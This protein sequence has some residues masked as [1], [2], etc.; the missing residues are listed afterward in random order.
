M[1][2]S[3]KFKDILLRD[4]KMIADNGW[5]SNTIVVDATNHGDC[6]S[7][8]AALMKKDSNDIIGINYM[9]VGSGS[10]DIE[11]LKERITAIEPLVDIANKGQV[12]SPG[13]WLW[14]KEIKSSDIEYLEDQGGQEVTTTKITNKLAIKVNFEKS[15][16]INDKLEFSEFALIGGDKDLKSIDKIFFINYVNHGIITKLAN[17]TI[18][19][20][21]H[22]TFLG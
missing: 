14:A 12:K 2:I 7:L 18:L 10:T 16:P 19:R 4:G 1:K 22:L 20:T 15:E 11:H 5:T 9:V 6:G 8:L 21:V 3:G 17:D 13:P